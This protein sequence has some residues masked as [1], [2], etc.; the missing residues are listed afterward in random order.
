MKV[1][2]ACVVVFFGVAELYQWFQHV[3]LPLPVY[4]VAGLL[5]ALA[6]NSEKLNRLIQA[7]PSQASL[8][9]QPLEQPIPEAQPSEAVAPAQNPQH[10]RYYPGPQLPNLNPPS[11]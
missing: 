3:T 6:S 4:G 9:E 7:A 8:S 5:L 2:A 11:R 1:W 10:P